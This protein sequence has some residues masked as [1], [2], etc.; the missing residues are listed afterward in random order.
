H[1]GLVALVERA[2]DVLLP[3]FGAFLIVEI[4][5]SHEGRTEVG[6]P[7]G[8]PHFRI[9]RTRRPEISFTTEA[10]EKALRRIKLLRKTAE[11][12]TVRSTLIAPPALRPLP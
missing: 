5:A 9:F 6:A 12:E 8:P 3:S 4:W 2:V 1:A 10:L 7:P 11:V